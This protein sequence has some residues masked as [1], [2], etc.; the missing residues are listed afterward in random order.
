MDYPFYRQQRHDISNNWWFFPND[1]LKTEKDIESQNSYKRETPILSY[2]ENISD[3]HK[4]EYIVITIIVIVFIYRLDLRSSLWVG[5][6]LALIIVYYLNEKNGQQ[7]NDEA[8][9]IWVILKGPILKDTKYFI[10]DP[11]LVRWVNDVS[12]FKKYNVLVFNKM[13]KTLD[14]MLRLIHDVKRGVRYCNENLDII[15]E[16]KTSSLNQFHSL[17]HNI[18]MPTLR[19]K[20]DHNLYELG[21]ILNDHIVKLT[22]ICKVYYMDKQIDIDT[23]FDTTQMSDPAPDDPMYEEN[24]NFY[25]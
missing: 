23:H 9:Q 21:K 8:S 24:Y 5:V 2:I 1:L 14:H 3:K 20:L 22:G 7:I 25:N 11:L 16:L 13:V 17:V 6:V 15:R 4:F 18:S 10:M 12:E 19:H